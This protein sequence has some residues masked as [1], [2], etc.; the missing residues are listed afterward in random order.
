MNVVGREEEVATMQGLLTSSESHFLAL[1]GRRRIGK[2]YLI[3][4]VYKS[5]IVFSMSGLHEASLD[6]QLQNFTLSFYNKTKKLISQ[7]KNWL[8]AF[9]ILIHH[10]EKSTRTKKVIFID[11]LPWLSTPRS[12]FLSSLEHFWNAWASK[13]SDIILVVCGSA[14]SWMIKNIVQNKGGLHNR[15]THTIRLMPFTLRES[16]LMLKKNGVILTHYQIAELYMITGGIPYYLKAV[17]KGMS[18]DQIVNDLCFKKD[19]LLRREFDYLF[20]SLF[21]QASSHLAIIQSLSKKNKGL[22]RTEILK[23]TKLPNAGSSTRLLEELEESGFIEK[24]QPFQNISKDAVYRLIDFYSLFYIKFIAKAKKMNNA[25]RNLSQL[26]QWK[27]WQGFAF[28]NLCSQ[29]IL[30]IKSKL[31]ISGVNTRETSWIKKGT[32]EEDGT[33]IDL[34]IDRDDNVISICEMKFHSNE[35]IIDKKYAQVLR[36]KLALFRSNSKTKKAVFLAMITSHGIK[37]NEY[38][39]ELIQNEVIINDLYLA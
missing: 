8:E 7:P 19:S 39:Y 16:A 3:E 6:E 27:I 2:T 28:E 5:N 21:Q 26:P 1:Y 38:Y 15:I 10:L 29:H 20:Q 13:R 35:F 30:Q 12:R 33:Q 4:E 22:T 34:L 9:Q 37:Q 11:E 24:N 17:K 31:G 25:Y 32:K 14:A 36:S 18:I 23:A